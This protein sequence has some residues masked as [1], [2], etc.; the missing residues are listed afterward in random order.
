MDT[1]HEYKSVPYTAHMGTVL[2]GTVPMSKIAIL[3]SYWCRE[4]PIEQFAKWSKA[5]EIWDV[6]VIQQMDTTH[7]G[8]THGRI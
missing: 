3:S 6:V 4:L 8:T 1:T 5:N 7:R 2:A